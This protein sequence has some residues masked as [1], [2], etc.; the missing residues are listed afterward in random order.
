MLRIGEL[1]SGVDKATGNLRTLEGYV[2]GGELERALRSVGDVH[3]TSAVDHLVQAPHSNDAALRVR[4][5]AGSLQ[6]AYFFYESASHR[7]VSR[8]LREVYAPR[9]L[10][11]LHAKQHFCATLVAVLFWYLNETPGNRETWVTRAAEQLGEYDRLMRELLEIGKPPQTGVGPHQAS[12]SIPSVLAHI[13]G[14]TKD[15]YL[16]EYATLAAAHANIAN[17][18][19]R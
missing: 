13:F 4:Q 11:S 5:A 3:L 9:G 15:E 14:P 2:V 12:V 10:I 16:A 7:G 17:R 18:I 8:F 6:D 1:I 19:L